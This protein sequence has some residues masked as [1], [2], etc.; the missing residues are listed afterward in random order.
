MVYSFVTYMSELLSYFILAVKKL[1]YMFINSSL[2]SQGFSARRDPENKVC[3]VSKVD[4]SFPSPGKMKVDMD[5]VGF[6]ENICNMISHE[7]GRSFL[8]L[9]GTFL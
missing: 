5:Q 8:L 9:F 6:V 2:S 7:I 3:Y 1:W 4:S